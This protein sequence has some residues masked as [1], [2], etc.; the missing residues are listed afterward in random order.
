MKVLDLYCGAGGASMGLKMAGF[1]TIIGVDINPQPEYPF[2]F[3]QNDVTKMMFPYYEDF[4]AQFDL[5]WA[6]PP[7]QA[8]SYAARRWHNEGRSYPDLISRTRKILLDSGK[9]FII[10][11]V[12]G[13]PIRKDLMLC[14]E[15]FGL[16]VIRHRYFEIHGFKVPQPNHK[17]HRGLV[18]DGYYVTV[19]GH[20]GNDSKHNYCKLNGLENKS[21]LEVWQ[22]AMGIDWITDK[23]MLAQAVPPAYSKYIGEMF[24]KN[25][26]SINF[27]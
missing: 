18:K 14:G 10:E 12:P 15:M 19:A 21:K 22:H 8:Y 24:L 1:D 23:K 11:N 17:K 5:I 9:P 4:Y 6:S 16:K 13:S 26:N 20:G 2:I 3:V 27:V 7:C 25:I